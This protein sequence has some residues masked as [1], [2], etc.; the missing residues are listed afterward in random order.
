MIKSLLFLLI[1]VFV[2]GYIIIGIGSRLRHLWAYFRS[3]WRQTKARQVADQS[4]ELMDEG[5]TPCR[6]I[7]RTQQ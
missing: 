1:E 3:R 6:L 5:K 7:D 2:A 4:I